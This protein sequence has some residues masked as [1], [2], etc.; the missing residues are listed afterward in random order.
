MEQQNIKEIQ[1]G[2]LL[3]HVVHY[4]HEGYRLVAI[5]ATTKDGIELSYSFDKEYDFIH[6]R[7]LIDS[8]TEIE[9]ISSLYSYAFL[10]ENEIKE[11]FGVQIKDI[12][13]DFNNQLYRIPVPTP[14]AAKEEKA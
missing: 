2:E 4:K 13:I 11:L 3:T 7:L 14:F 12:S 10:Y 8:A 9:S 6:L 1:P 5:S